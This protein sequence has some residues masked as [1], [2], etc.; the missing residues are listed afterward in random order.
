MPNLVIAFVLLTI[1]GLTTY[2]LHQESQTFL[3]VE[4]LERG[5]TPD[6]LNWLK[7]NGYE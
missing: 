3:T 7:V 5:F 1:M 4:E 2:Y 6:F